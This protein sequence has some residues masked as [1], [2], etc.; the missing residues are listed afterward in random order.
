MCRG[1]HYELVL[2]ALVSEASRAQVRDQGVRRYFGDD[3][4]P[5]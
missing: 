5:D 1:D 2:S 3:W 4:T